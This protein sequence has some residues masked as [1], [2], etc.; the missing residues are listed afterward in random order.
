[1]APGSLAHECS[2]YIQVFIGTPCREQPRRGRDALLR[3]VA[4]NSEPR[5]S[6]GGCIGQGPQH[7]QSHPEAFADLQAPLEPLKQ[8]RT[9]RRAGERRPLTPEVADGSR[10][11]PPM[12][13]P[14]SRHFA[15]PRPAV[16]VDTVITATR[17][18][19]VESEYG[20]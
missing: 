6:P 7:P 1:M 8:R 14:I 5:G 20:G 9:R 16:P 13:E 17:F 19:A 10:V 15:E 11:S 18:L 12:N 4:P 3:V 2:N